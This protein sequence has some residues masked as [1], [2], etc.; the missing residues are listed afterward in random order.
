MNS[1]EYSVGLYRTMYV[2][3][4][5]YSITLASG[6]SILSSMRQRHAMV[7]YLRMCAL[8]CVVSFV[9]SSQIAVAALGLLFHRDIS[10]N[11]PHRNASDGGSYNALSRQ[12]Y[13]LCR[14]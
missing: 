9:G 2:L 12:R 7:K 10:P 5:Y 14:R 11:L 8:V 1:T 3:Y 13:V 6:M 4:S